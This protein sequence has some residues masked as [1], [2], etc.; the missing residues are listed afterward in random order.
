MSDQT[1]MKNIKINNKYLKGILE[2]QALNK[3]LKNNLISEDAY[4][5]LKEK[6]VNEYHIL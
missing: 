1:I 6:I 4:N 3:V 2:L 5:Y